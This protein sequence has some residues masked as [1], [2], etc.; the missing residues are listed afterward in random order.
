[1][2]LPPFGLPARA[3][4]AAASEPAGGRPTV[5]AWALAPTFSEA[6]TEATT[7]WKAVVVAEGKAG[8][9]LEEAAEEAAFFAFA[10][11]SL[12]FLP[13]PMVHRATSAGTARA[14]RGRAASFL[15]CPERDAGAA[16]V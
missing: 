4:A 16:L 5:A 3:L 11:A 14:E 15:V 1:M 7:A 6:F 12:A 13:M 8:G 9:E 2:T 10:A